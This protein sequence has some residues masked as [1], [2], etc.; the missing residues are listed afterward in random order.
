MSIFSA[1]VKIAN[2]VTRSL[3]AQSYVTHYTWIRSDDAGAPVYDPPIKRI[4][5]VDMQQKDY[6]TSSGEMIVT[7]AYI[8]ILEPITPHGAPGRKE[9]VDP[10]DVFVLPD[11]TSGP[12]VDIGGFI[13]GE[14][15]RPLFSEIWLG[16]GSVGI[17]G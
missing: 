17:P 7:A 13:S 2:K 9:P 14:T 15:D 3:K 4:A 1:G 10:N 11:G 8:G 12:I 6:R 16:V 5:I